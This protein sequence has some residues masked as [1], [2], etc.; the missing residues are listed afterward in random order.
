MARRVDEER[1][2]GDRVGKE[3]KGK[4]IKDLT[5]HVKTLGFS[6]WCGEAWSVLHLI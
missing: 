3:G 6:S 2:I 1:A 5:G 4:I